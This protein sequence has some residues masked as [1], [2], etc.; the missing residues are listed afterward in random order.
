[1]Q[2]ATT[3]SLQMGFLRPLEGNQ[4]CPNLIEI[5]EERV[6]RLGGFEPPTCGL[7]SRGASCRHVQ[8]PL[9]LRR[10]PP[11]K[12]DVARGSLPAGLELNATSGVVAGTPTHGGTF[13]FTVRVTDTGDPPQTQMRTF[14]GKAVPS[15]V[16]DLKRLPQV[17]EDGIYG[18]VEVENSTREDFDLT[19]IVLAVSEYGK[20]FALGYQ[21]FVLERG[22][23]SREIPFGFSL[24]HGDYVVHVDAVAEE[25][26]TNAIYRGWRQQGPMRV[27]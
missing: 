23:L 13:G 12:W 24:P 10:A 9:F 27:E 5:K 20:A 7:G 6:E 19:V 17:E 8:N 22:T 3:V 21:H 1:M 15:L 14:M 4:I 25:A 2:Q 26:P 18:S 11:L 16:V